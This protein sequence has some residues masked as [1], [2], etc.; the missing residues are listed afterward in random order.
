MK[1]TAM[2]RGIG[3]L[4]AGTAFLLASPLVTFGIIQ[5]TV[6]YRIDPYYNV[7]MLLLALAYLVLAFQ[8]VVA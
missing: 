7:V 1:R 8:L 5:P 6:F 4:A 3:P 2:L